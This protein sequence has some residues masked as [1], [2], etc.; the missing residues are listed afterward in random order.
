MRVRAI[1]T[2]A[3]LS[4]LAIIPSSA[5]A[6]PPKSKLRFSATSSAVAEN[7]G[8]AHIAVTRTPRNGKTKSATNSVA[9]VAYSASNGTAIA[10]TD[11]TAAKGRLTFPACSGSPAAT[12]PCMR[13]TIDIAIADDAV[14]DGNKTVKLALSS[15]SRNSVVVNPQKATLTIADNEGPNHITFDASDYKVWELGP[16]AE[17]HVVRSGAGISGSSAVDFSTANGT[18]TSPGDY[19]ASSSTLSYAAGEVDKTVL[20]DIFDDSVVEAS[21][22]FDVRLA[23]A[24]GG[25][26]ID[27][28]SAPVTI[29]DDDTSVPAHL[30]LDATT[31]SVGEGG[32]VT[33]TVNRTSSVSGPV[34]VDYATV[35]Q[36]AGADVDFTA[37]ADTLDFDPGDTSE[38]FTVSSLADSLHESDETF[39]LTLSNAVPAGTVL[40]SAGATVT[41]T[42]D[43][44][45]PT[46]SSGGTTAGGGNVTVVV[47]LSNPSTQDVTVTYVITDAAGNQ[48]GTGTV[49][50]PAGSTSGQVVVP[51]SGSGPYTVTLSNPSGGTLDSAHSSSTSPSTGGG[52]GGTPAQD[53]T[54]SVTPSQGGGSGGSGSTGSN[55]TFDVTISAPTDHPVTVDYEIHDANGATIGT[56][57]VTIPAGSTTVTVTVPVPA[58][59]Q[60]PVSVVLVHPSGATVAP[61]AG[62]AAVA[63]TSSTGATSNPSGM[64]AANLVANER[65]AG[66]AAPCKLSFKQGRVSKRTGLMKVTLKAGRACT[67]ITGASVK[68]TK[69]TKLITTR[70]LRALKTKRQT[71]RLRNGQKRTL[72]LRF[73]ARGLGF[74][75]RAAAAKRPLTLT[76][77]VIER[78]VAK[79]VAKHTLRTKLKLG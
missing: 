37:A 25:A 39:G 59:T 47:Q 5:L 48:V 36:T 68:A 16:Q 1:T 26:T 24:T 44:P 21:E 73:S 27:T 75:K 77:V 23:G 40:D 29:L 4:A 28:P 42:D 60:G 32:D 65:L 12:D 19:T 17:V 30:A 76:L 20:V 10:G 55:V 54:V 72:T 13:Q 69:P 50:I 64:T 74:I 70:V 33:F 31:Y 57:T 15:P 18:A 22:T 71:I 52:G 9:S 78:D 8:T 53:P 63:V 14:I 35:A 11:F 67:V 43:D 2:L 62:S 6:G 58:G 56:G 7:A 3:A 79:R 45:L 41:I 49:T 34:S 46:I 38:S 61:G 66:A 51:V